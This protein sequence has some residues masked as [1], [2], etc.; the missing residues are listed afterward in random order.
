MKLFF[1]LTCCFTLSLSANSLAQQERVSL[2]MKNVG[3]EELFDEVQRQTKLYF[4]FNIEQVKPLGKI[5]LDVE[6]ETVESVLMSVFKDSDLTYVFNGNMIVVRPRDAQ[7]DKEVKKIVITGKV[8]DTKKQPLPGV[9]VQM[10]GVAI[11][12]ATDLDGKYSLT[13]PGAPEKFTLVYSFVGMVTQEVIYAGKD[14]INVVMKEDVETRNQADQMVYQSEKTLSE[15]GDKIPADDKSKV[16][17]GID[18]LKE[19]LKGTDTAAI[20]TATDE[21]TQ[22]FYA[23]SEKLYQQANPQGA[24]GGAQQQAGPDAGAQQGQY[25]DAD[26]KVVDDDENNKK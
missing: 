17:A 16:Q 14:T 18:K 3:V 6:N 8:S 2:K 22:A 11:G 20:K 21:L 23:V 24:Q 7:E 10:K 12:T 1:L 26:Y 4:L 13:I 15:M 5:S 19:V 25:Y 9:T